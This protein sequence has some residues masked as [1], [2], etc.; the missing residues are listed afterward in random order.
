MPQQ[1]PDP[2]VPESITLGVFSGIRNTV[3][4][5]RLSPNELELG[6]NIDI[7]DAGQVRRRRGFTLKDSSSWHSVRDV[8]G[9]VYG[10]KDGTLG[11]I[12]SDYSFASL[13]VTVGPVPVCYALVDEEV[14]FSSADASGVIAHNE[15]VREWGHTDGQGLWFSPV[16]TP[17]DTLGAVGGTLLGDPPKATSI[18]SYKGRIY[19]A[20]KKML[21]ATELYRF[22]YVDRTRNFYQFENDITLVRAV[23][24]GLY[25]GTTGG[26]NF[27]QGVFGT[28]KLTPITTEPVLAGSDVMV[29]TELV[30][31]QASSGPVPT[32]MSLVCMSDGGILVGLDGGTCFNLTRGKVEFPKGVGAAGLFR[33]DQGANYY[34]AAVDSAGGPAANARIGDYVE[35]ELIRAADR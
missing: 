35:A 17:T 26:L 7:D 8:A 6:V 34:V 29:P 19:L 1:P 14:Y 31:P 22:N 9:K 32:N 4:R 2:N 10:A 20:S 11:I 25:V 24:D 33:Q 13:G 15:T 18:E 27:L 16:Y 5:E 21:W 12:R 30:H 28:F 23:D 3:S